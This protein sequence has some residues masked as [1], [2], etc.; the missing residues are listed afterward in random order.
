MLEAEKEGES[1][2]MWIHALDYAVHREVAKKL[3]EE[4]LLEEQ[5]GQVLDLPFKMKVQSLMDSNKAIDELTKEDVAQRKKEE[6][7]EIEANFPSYFDE[8]QK[9]LLSISF[10]QPSKLS[11]E[12]NSRV[13]VKHR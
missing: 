6:D 10:N 11:L 13:E 1:D 7:L 12:R 8:F 4:Q 3:A 9:T 5:E 2:Q